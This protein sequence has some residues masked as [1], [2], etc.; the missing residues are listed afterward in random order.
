[1]AW[2]R[3]KAVPLTSK[4]VNEFSN[5]NFGEPSKG[6]FS[7]NANFGESS[8]RKSVKGEEGKIA[9]RAAEVYDCISSSLV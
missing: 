6:K 4:L 9:V 2:D 7:I 8:R 1:M 5:I 3:A